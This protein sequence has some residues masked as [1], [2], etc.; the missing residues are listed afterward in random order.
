M[1]IVYE[2]IDTSDLDKMIDY[3]RNEI[4][5]HGHEIAYHLLNRQLDIAIKLKTERMWLRK[6]KF[7]LT[8]EEYD[9]YILI[10]GE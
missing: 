6:F 3:L 9:N 10:K 5:E 7:V 2:E 1:D 8:Q 4:G